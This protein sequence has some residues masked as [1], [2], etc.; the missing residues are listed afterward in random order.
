MSYSKQELIE[1]LIGF[2]EEYGRVPTRQDFN[3]GRIKPSKTTYYR[4]FGSIEDAV[5]QAEL[6]RRGELVA[7][8]KREIR[9][10]K[11][12]SKKGEFQCAF[13]GNYTSDVERYH[14]NLAK[15]IAMRFINFLKS[16]KGQDYYDAVMDCIH[17]VFGGNNPIMKEELVSAGYLDA[18]EQRHGKGRQDQEYKLRCDNCDQWK[19]DR[20]ITIDD[21]TVAKFICEDCI[22]ESKRKNSRK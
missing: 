6:Y 12:V 7:E 21:S 17:A 8:D 20:L 22:S 3:A 10:V 19:W 15:I 5:K 9:S 14:S 4:T 18:F 13:C 11:A 16:N 2:K 1:N